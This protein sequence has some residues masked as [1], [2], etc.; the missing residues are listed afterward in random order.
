[1][2]R[3]ACSLLAIIAAGSAAGQTLDPPEVDFILRP[4]QG[5]FATDPDDFWAN[6][7][8][9]PPP[10]PPP[11]AGPTGD[12]PI[13][14]PLAGPTGATPIGPPLAGPQPPPP[15]RPR[16]VRRVRGAR[17]A[18][19]ETEPFGQAGIALGTFILRPAI[20]IGVNAT[21]NVA[22]SR[23]EQGAVG[24]LVAPEL[25]L[26]TEDD[27]Y[28]VEA[29]I[30]AEAI[31]YGEDEFDER[32]ADARIVGRYELTSR[33][34]IEAEAGYSYDLERFNDPDTPDA[35]AERPAVQE[36]EAQLGATHRLGRLGLG[37]SGA[38]Q[39]EVNEDVTLASGETISRRELDTTEYALRQRTSYELS[40]AAIPFGEVAIG[41]R[42]FDQ[43]VD[44]DG[45]ERS[46][47]WGELRGGLLFDRGEKLRGEVALGYRREE[48][49]D[50]RLEPL[51]VLIADASVI[52]SPRRL[53]ELRLEFDT[54]TGSTG[55]P[56]ASGTV[57]YSGAFIASRQVGARL[58]LEAGAQLEYERFVGAGRRDVTFSAFAGA[59]YALNRFSALVG[60]Y[61][62]ER[63]DSTDNE[64][65]TDENVVSLR[66]RLQR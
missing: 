1:M 64:S 36:F 38:V 5:S 33:T 21:D 4:T 53:T 39:R 46:A 37:L 52:W 29:L 10:P 58:N 44:D 63:T 56:G 14:P 42:E 60:R 3:L 59:S 47:L 62:Y 54:E 30:D 34:T 49:D 6:Q 50:D 24:L 43:P 31:F 20:E 55:L 35:A 28:R 11:L 66:L 22:D 41:R 40:R 15:S 57:L 8:A 32:D 16:P 23:D 13:G 25:S 9:E 45:F 7:L 2:L 12:E 61:G 26:V 18:L 19:A 48:L 17:D 65:D 51:D 27:R